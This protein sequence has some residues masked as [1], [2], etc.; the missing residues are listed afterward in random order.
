MFLSFI[1]INEEGVVRNFSCQL[2]HLEAGF[3]FLS[4]LVAAGDTLLEV[5]IVEQGSVI[6]LPPESFDGSPFLEAIQ[7]L[8]HE[9]NSIL[10]GSKTPSSS[11]EY[12][13]WNQTWI[14]VYEKRI[15]KLESTI[16]RVEALF[17]KATTPALINHYQKVLDHYQAQLEKAY[18]I[19]HHLL[20]RHY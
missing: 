7:Q 15:V 1:A 20:D 5:S 18:I 3:D 9:W 12:E 16:T 10:N 6:K 2:S 17:R 11:K 13:E 19:R 4:Q 8:E 14:T